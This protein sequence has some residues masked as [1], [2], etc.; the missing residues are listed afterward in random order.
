MYF[1]LVKILPQQAGLQGK[2]IKVGHK[3]PL[4]LNHSKSIPFNYF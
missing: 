1:T 3:R 4:I 2:Q